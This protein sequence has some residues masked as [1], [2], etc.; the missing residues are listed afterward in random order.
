MILVKKE[1]VYVSL[2]PE[3]WTVLLLFSISDL[4]PHTP[5]RP[6]PFRLHPRKTRSMISILS[7][8]KPSVTYTM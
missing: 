3:Y 1:L 4:F 7:H 6:R 2:A 8:V 5:E